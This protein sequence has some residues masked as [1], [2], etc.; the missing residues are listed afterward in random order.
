[1]DEMMNR[2]ASLKKVKG[3]TEAEIPPAPSPAP[4]QL[5]PTIIT[6]VSKKTL[7]FGA[8]IPGPP[9]MPQGKRPNL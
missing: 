2:G 1:M 3:K 9:Q 8:T 7:D 4:I 5:K 6:N